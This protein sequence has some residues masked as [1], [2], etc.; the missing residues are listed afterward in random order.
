MTASEPK[1]SKKQNIIFPKLIVNSHTLLSAELFTV[2]SNIG[3]EINEL[4]NTCS[5]VPIFKALYQVFQFPRLR[6]I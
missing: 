2:Q 4:H 1:A 6:D 3:Y 5:A